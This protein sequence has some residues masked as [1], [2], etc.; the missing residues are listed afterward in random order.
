MY[1]Q[2]LIQCFSLEKRCDGQI[3]CPD[4]SDEADC[5]KVKN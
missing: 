5:A 1:S 4:S 3:N 2:Q